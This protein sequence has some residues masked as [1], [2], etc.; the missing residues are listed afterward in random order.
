MLP[1][2]QAGSII[3]W[4]GSILSIPTGWVLCDGT[5]GTPDLR[6]QFVVGSG[7]TYSVDETGGNLNHNHDFDAGQ[8]HHILAG[9]TV[10]GTPFGI[11]TDTSPAFVTGTTDDESSL[12]TYYSLAKIM[13]LGS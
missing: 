8:H 5:N 10:L 4:S 9:G 1:S 13:F 12:P 6:N 2:V 7:D 3:S 11:D